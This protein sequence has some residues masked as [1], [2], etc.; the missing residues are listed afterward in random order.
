MSPMVRRTLTIENALLGLLQQGSLHGY[1]L[2]KQLSDPDGLG[3]VWRLK[4]AQLYALLDRFEGDGY[5]TSS[6]QPQEARPARRVYQLTANGKRAFQE[7]LSCPVQA[8]RQIRQEFQAKLF[9]A[10]RETPEVRSRLVETQRLACQHWLENY[11][12]QNVE[13]GEA[14]SYAWLVDQYRLGQIQA[15]LIWLDLCDTFLEQSA[16]IKEK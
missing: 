8:P 12:S 6:L 16:N 2:H 3:R 7:W 1:Q 14:P 5:I 11:Q 15:V 13:E 10:H 4:Q 9:F